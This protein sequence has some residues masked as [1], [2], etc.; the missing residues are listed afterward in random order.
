[1]YINY[2]YYRIFYYVA[3]YGSFTKAADFL[4]SNQPNITRSVKKLEGELGCR[5]FNRSNRGVSLTPDGE[6]LFSHVSIAIDQIQAAE[7]ELAAKNSLESGLV[8]IGASEIALHGILLSAIKRFHTEYPGIKVRISNHSTPQAISSVKDKYVDFAVV[9]TPTGD[10]SGLTAHELRSFRD[11]P[12][13]GK[14]YSLLCKK[15]LSLKELSAY[16]VISLNRDTKTYE[17]YNTLYMQNNLNFNP[18]IEVATTD[19]ILP[20]VEAGLGIGFVPEFL[21]SE[22]LNAKRV[23]KLNVS[24]NI[25]QRSICLISDPKH[26]LSVA[27]KKLKEF[28]FSV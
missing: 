3:K 15:Q 25:P 12:I 9:S 28:L 13:C 2:D 22:A 8:F 19:Q 7:E 10:I 1:M 23:F 26:T 6:R 14:S 27:A 18:E 11:I 17:F 21:V 20:M 16:P 5:L 24:V 4:L